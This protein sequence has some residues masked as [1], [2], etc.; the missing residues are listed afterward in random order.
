[1]SSCFDQYKSEG[2]LAPLAEGT[3]DAPAIPF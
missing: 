3:G 1:M 2:D